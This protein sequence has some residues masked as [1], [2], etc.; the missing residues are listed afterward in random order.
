MKWDVGVQTGSSSRIRTGGRQLGMKF[1]FHKMWGTSY[2]QKNLIIIMLLFKL[3]VW[4]CSLLVI[5][6]F[7]VYV[8]FIYADNQEGR[9]VLFHLC[10]FT[11]VYEVYQINKCSC[12]A[13]SCHWFLGVGSF[14]CQLP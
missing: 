12:T 5:H 6:I 2:F 10:I 11:A 7:Y 13:L 8:S 1:G 4:Y 14:L 3:K 9:R